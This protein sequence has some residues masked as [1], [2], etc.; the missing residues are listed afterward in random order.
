MNREQSIIPIGTEETLMLL[1]AFTCHPWEWGDIIED[2]KLN[3]DRL[4]REVQVLYRNATVQELK[5]RLV[6]KLQK[7]LLFNQP[8]SNI[9]IR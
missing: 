4:P 9:Q 1:R 8:D 3:T 5:H 7:L 2:I 6:M